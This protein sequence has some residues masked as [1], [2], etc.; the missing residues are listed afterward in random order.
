MNKVTYEVIQHDGG[1]AYK[2]DGSFSETFAS[3]ADALEAANRAA[4]EQKVPAETRAI[5]YQDKMGRWHE[6]TD[7]GDDRPATSVVDVA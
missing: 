2:V 1:W 6:E 5:A 3:H 4:H 7:R